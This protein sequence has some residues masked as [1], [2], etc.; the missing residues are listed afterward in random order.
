M[1][2]LTKNQLNAEIKQV[3]TYM[4]G[5]LA[6]KNDWI[7]DKETDGEGAYCLIGAY[8]KASRDLKCISLQAKKKAKIVIV[9][10]I[11]KNYKDANVSLNCIIT[12]YNDD[13][14]RTHN[15]II[16]LLDKVA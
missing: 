9:Q 2:T 4:K 3:I 7:K 6:N 10:N 12:E 13:Y 1:S 5:L 11:D 15:Q 16:N 14:N 8:K